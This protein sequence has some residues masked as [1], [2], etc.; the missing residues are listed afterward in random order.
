[1]PV[2][3]KSSNPILRNTLDNNNFTISSY[4]NNQP[5]FLTRN[6]VV[7]ATLLLLFVVAATAFGVISIGRTN[8]GLALSLNI[9][10]VFGAIIMGL[11]VSFNSKA[12]R[13]SAILSIVFAI[14][15]GLMVGG[16]TYSIGM[17]LNIQGTSGINVV[18]QAII[19]TISLFFV[20][21]ILYGTKI[22]DVNKKFTTF[23][24]YASMG[25]GVMYLVNFVISLITGT[26]LLF[27]SGPIPIIIG[28]IAIILGC[29]SLLVDLKNVDVATQAGV[30]EQFK[31]TLAIG[32]MTSIV[33]IYMEILRVLYLSIT[34]QS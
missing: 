23:V 24:V 29:M 9:V 27:S 3:T 19:G 21:M 8:P 5:G 18:L 20:A 26:N 4:G 12:Q 28:V 13:G 16:F 7:G 25:F 6:N 30:P 10:G 17:N 22:I 32:I 14:F 31:W 1:M 34:R 15:E 2:Q 33:W 11:V